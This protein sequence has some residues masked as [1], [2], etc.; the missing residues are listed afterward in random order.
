MSKQTEKWKEEIKS[1]EKS[2][3]EWGAYL[4]EHQLI[5]KN[6]TSIDFYEIQRRQEAGNRLMNDIK[7]AKKRIELLKGKI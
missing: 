2:I 1:L 7:K 5:L 4:K 3:P 6:D